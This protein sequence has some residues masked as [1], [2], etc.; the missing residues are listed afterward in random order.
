MRIWL[1]TVGEP[2]PTDED[3]PRLHR[4][5]MLSDVM[6]KRGHEVV[7]WSSTFNHTAK[8]SRF[9]HPVTLY[10]SPGS[11][12]KLLH[13]ISYGNSVSLA[14]LYNHH[15]IG[16]QF[17]R[18]APLE[19]PPHL[20]LASMPT[21]ELSLAAARY[22]ASRNIPVVLDM[23]D[24]WPD[25]FVNLAPLPLRPLANLV[26]RPLA[27]ML[28]EAASKATAITGITEPFVDWG[29]GYAG[30]QA[31][32]QDRWFP[33]A[34][35][36]GHPTD[37]EIEAGF[38]FWESHGIK[39]GAGGFI[40]CFFGM[41]GRQFDMETVIMAARMIAA[42]RPDIRFVLCGSGDNLETYKSSSA[43]CP[44]ILLPGWVNKAQ[45]WTLMRLASAGLA[46]YRS[47]TD[48]E[49]SYPNKPIEYMS[50]GLPIVSS[51]KG[52]LE[53]LLIERE[54]GLTYATGDSQGLAKALISLYEDSAKIKRMSANAQKTFD[55]MFTAEKVYSGMVDYLEGIEFS[56]LRHVA[57]APKKHQNV[58]Q[59]DAQ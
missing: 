1:L 5:G 54:C 52:L 38:R 37:I 4:S 7:W 40:A 45:V 3:K 12:L 9:T 19:P 49:I 35:S 32:A 14:R 18:L 46:P 56:D 13:S 28:R 30:R 42:G 47:S 26:L 41:M 44:N 15:S 53:N 11:T 25:I 33:L 36:S 8:T 51:L 22:G 16:R 21:I 55:E 17:A 31:T 2:L 20:I 59:Q 58:M 34:Y 24:M 10:P 39:R 48:F 57:N 50:A 29:L 6:L 27:S 23:R 43:G